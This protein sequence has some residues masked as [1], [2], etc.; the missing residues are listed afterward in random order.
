MSY[1]SIYL[2]LITLLCSS[3][4]VLSEKTIEPCKKYHG[5]FEEVYSF[6]Q[7]KCDDSVNDCPK[8]VVV[9]TTKLGKNASFTFIPALNS[10]ENLDYT[11]VIKWCDDTSIEYHNSYV[12]VRK[13]TMSYNEKIML[14]TFGVILLFIILS[15][16]SDETSVSDGS[17]MNGLALGMLMSSSSNKNIRGISNKW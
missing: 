5:V 16:S 4:L 3:E 12:K 6:D 11:I 15:S 10:K 9:R 1:I 17:Y 14:I 8:A 13:K 7:V 2:Y